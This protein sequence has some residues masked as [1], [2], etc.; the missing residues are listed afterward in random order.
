[1]SDRLGYRARLERE[2]NFL[3]VLRSRHEMSELFR[4]CSESR[5]SA[6][7]FYRVPKGVFYFHPEL[8]I[9]DIV[10]LR[11]LPRFANTLLANDPRHVGLINLA[12]VRGKAEGCYDDLFQP[13]EGDE[14]LVR[15]LLS[16]L[17][18]VIFGYDGPLGRAVHPLEARE[19]RKRRWKPQLHRSMIAVNNTRV[20]DRD[21]ALFALGE[22]KEQWD[23][24]RG[25]R[26]SKGN[27]CEEDDD[28]LAS[29]YGF[30][31]FPIEAFGHI[32]N[33]APSSGPKDYQTSR[34]WTSPKHRLNIKLN[35]LP[36]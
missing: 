4:V 23:A 10:G 18:R 17:G 14:H 25:E 5:Q 15:R 24:C 19:A 33:D 9:V 29:A 16:R 31:L 1:M 3:V 32:P 8:D 30:W 20:A 28:E 21:E 6:M 36:F 35:R 2:S 27:P 7:R 13:T 34:L 11:Y 22:E 12:S 26:I